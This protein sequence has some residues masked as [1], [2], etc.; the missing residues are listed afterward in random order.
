MAG[1]AV[2]GSEIVSVIQSSPAVAAPVSSCSAPSMSPLVPNNGLK[3]NYVKLSCGRRVIV[4][5]RVS[6]AMK[7]EARIH[8]QSASASTGT[9]GKAMAVLEIVAA[10]DEPMRFTDILPLSDQPRGTLHRQLSH[11]VD[12]GLLALGS[13]RTYTLGLRLLRLAA[14]SW[15]DN[16]FRLV[17]EPHLRQ[18]HRST[19]GTVHLGVLSGAE[20]VYLDKIEGNQTVRMH[21]QI[22]KASPAHCTGVGKAALSCLPDERLVPLVEAMPF[23]RFTPATIA[24]PQELLDEIARIRRE[25]VA[26]DLEEHEPGIGCVAAPVYTADRGLVAAVSVTGPRYGMDPDDLSHWARAVR[27]AAGAITEELKVRMAPRT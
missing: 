23:H 7:S 20:V 4:N 8:A 1:V 15:A 2:T 26:Y 5:S 27:M 25:G 10:S 21:S 12:E 3:F 11:L 14:Q 9:L 13:G 24:T 19:G 16:R 18:L 6:F 17:A 22:G